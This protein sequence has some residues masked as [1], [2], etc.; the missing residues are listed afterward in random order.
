MSK[1]RIVWIVWTVLALGACTETPQ[2][3]SQNA[4][5]DTAAFQ[6][7]HGAFNAAGW[8]PG[9][10]TSWEQQLKTRQQMGQNE[11]NKVH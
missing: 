1:R 3:V 8:K 10:K 4:R 5:Q 11:Y 9:D 6:G 2:S 7:T